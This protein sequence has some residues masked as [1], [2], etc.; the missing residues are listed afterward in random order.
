[1]RQM[2][3]GPL[4]RENTSR[5]AQGHWKVASKVLE[6]FQRGLIGRNIAVTQW[7]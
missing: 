5:I 2:K 6:L 1:M 3:G 7:M 4:D